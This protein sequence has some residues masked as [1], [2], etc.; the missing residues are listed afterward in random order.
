M[1]DPLF[2]GQ[3]PTHLLW[4]SGQ[5]A[6]QVFNLR[7][8]R[9]VLIILMTMSRGFKKW[10]K[11]CERVRGNPPPLEYSFPTPPLPGRLVNPF[12]PYKQLPLYR[13]TG[14]TLSE[15][16][17]SSHFFPWYI[18]I[19]SE[20]YTFLTGDHAFTKRYRATE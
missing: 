8:T 16:T 6:Y 10:E 18:M 3:D 9:L 13:H 5:P 11:F 14:L 7:R 4:V 1:V 19:R 17:D 12:S 2:M 15:H 20:R